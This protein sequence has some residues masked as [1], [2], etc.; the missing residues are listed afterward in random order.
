MI[1]NHNT[2]TMK[3]SLI[4]ILLLCPQLLWARP[5]NQQYA[6]QVAENFINTPQAGGDGVRRAPAKP[7]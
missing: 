1:N 2:T 5:I 7:L 4:A 3:R 6:L